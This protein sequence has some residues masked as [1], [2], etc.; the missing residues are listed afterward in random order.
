M[1][2]LLLFFS[3]FPLA[4]TLAARWW[5][6]VRVL[7][8]DGSRP[9][10]CDLGRWLPAPG[11]TAMVHRAEESAGEFG[12]QLRLKAHAEWDARDP[13]AAASRAKTL[14][15]GAAVPPLSGVVA[16]LAVIVGK[17]P[18]IGALAILLGATA[19]A[20]VMGVLALASELTAIARTARKVRDEHSFPRRDDED[21]VVRCAIAHAWNASLPP[22]L[23]WF[24]G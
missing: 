13:R 19:L 4:A 16:V 7:V 15:F 17:V 20:A 9:C 18:V 2:R 3:L 12:R 6:G 23:R 14:R 5:F 22:I 10:R 8:S 21:A 1:F 24:N 11:D